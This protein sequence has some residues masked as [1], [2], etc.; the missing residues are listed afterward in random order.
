M[1]FWLMG[2]P[3]AGKTTLG[4]K[5][6]SFLQTEKKNWR[7]DVF[8]IDGDELRKLSNN[9]DYSELGRI[10]NIKSAQM[11]CRFVNKNDCDVVVSVV[12]PYRDIRENFKKEMGSSMV[13]IYVHTTDIRG[14]EQ[15]HVKE[16]EE[17]LEDFI[18]VDTTDTKVKKSFS[19]LI[20]KLHLMEIL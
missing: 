9:Y 20:N 18:S 15:Y 11:L 6:F 12:T 16:F 7:K 3:G 8:H 19:K 10:N 14:R 2:Q 1:I 17:P 4:K 5:L 13:E